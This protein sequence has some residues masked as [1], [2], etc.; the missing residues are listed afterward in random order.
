MFANTVYLP[1]QYGRLELNLHVSLTTNNKLTLMV[2]PASVFNREMYHHAKDCTLAKTN[3]LILNL[4]SVHN[5]KYAGQ[6]NPFTTVL[7]PKLIY[8]EFLPDH[9]C[10]EPFIPP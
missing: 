3:I 4:L 10:C 7:M 1:K 2:W 8:N 6:H 5:A 9:C